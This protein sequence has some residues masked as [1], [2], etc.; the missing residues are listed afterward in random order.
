MAKQRRRDED[1][2]EVVEEIE[3]EDDDGGAVSS[4]VPYKNPFGLAAYYCGIFSLLPVGV[5]LGPVAVILGIVGFVKSRSTRKAKGMGHSIAG[6][7][8]G[9]A[10]FFV[11][12]P[13]WTFLI[14][15]FFMK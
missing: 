4:V 7:C 15:R 14:L 9:L 2:D 12:G 5:C 6:V 1:E 13:L 10:G 3:D 8:L 11:M